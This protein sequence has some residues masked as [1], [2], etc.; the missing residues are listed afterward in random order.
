MDRRSV[1]KKTGLGV[2]ALSSL[3][4]ISTFA[5]TTASEETVAW[6]IY[7]FSKH[8]HWASYEEMAKIVANIGYDGI[9]LTVRPKGHVEPENVERDLPKVAE[10]LSKQGLEIGM[11]TTAILSADEPYTE[12]ILKT[13]SGLGIKVYRPGWFSYDYSI[14]IPDNIKKFAVE[15]KKIGELNEKYGIMGDYQNHSGT[16]GGSPVWDIHEM[17]ELAHT[18]WIGVQY[19]IRHAM[20][21]GFKSWPL[22]LRLLASHIHSIDIKDYE[23]VKTEQGWDIRNV[24]LGQGTV[25]FKSYFQLLNELKIHAPLAVHLEYPLGGADHGNFELTIP[26]EKVIEA[27]AN[28]LKYLRSVL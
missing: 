13:A 9:D 27:M 5:S 12:K 4:A 22:G 25:D 16:S 18:D 7:V 3:D 28:D 8:L 10:A 14:S 21:E 17:L 2:L 11:M 20:V 6:K 1:I 19:D 24:P 23:Y 26:K 15:L